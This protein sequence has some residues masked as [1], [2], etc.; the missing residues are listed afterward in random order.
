L[1]NRSRKEE[2]EDKS[3]TRSADLHELSSGGR[4]D[5]IGETTDEQTANGKNWGSGDG[6]TSCN[7]SGFLVF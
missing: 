4:T 5:Q 7:V 3:D 1:Q 2:P 6:V